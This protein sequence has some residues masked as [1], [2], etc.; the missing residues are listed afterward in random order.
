MAGCAPNATPSAPTPDIAFTMTPTHTL[1]PIPSAT[2]VP[3]KTPSPTP[4]RMAPAVD[5]T[6]L[7]GKVVFGYQGW[8]SCIGDG[9]GYANWQTSGSWIHWFRYYAEPIADALTVDFWP[10]TSEL[11]EDEICMTDMSLPDGRPA[12]AFSSYNLQTVV[13]HFQWMEEYGIDGVELNRFVTGLDNPDHLDFR[14]KVAQNVRTGA[15]I[16]G[17]FF[18]I[19]YDISGYKG[20]SLVSDIKSDWRHLVNTLKLTESPQYLHHRGLPVVGLYGFG[21]TGRNF[22]PDQTIELLDFFQSGDQLEYR[23]TV[24]GG[25]PSYWRTGTRD[26][27]KG[28]EWAQ[29]FR[30]FDIISPWA[31]GRFANYE[32]ADIFTREVTIPDLRETDSLGID[33]MPLVF[34]GFSWS[35]LYPSDPINSIPR[36]GGKFYWRQVFNAKSAGAK[37]L[38]IAMFDEVDEGTA[39][40]KLAATEQELPEGGVLVPLDIDGY[41]L[42]S[43]WYLRIGGMTGQMLREEIPLSTYLPIQPESLQ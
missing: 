1:T 4:T 28:P 40:F 42:P 27:E 22:T 18:Y 32:G 39:M 41:D 6:T 15:E 9:A 43:D 5:S 16:H 23:A 19:Q 2:L 7:E 31:V 37:M 35:N 36:N 17:R 20:S 30:S 24:K 13:R 11:T 8:F 34:P 29:V 25:V 38:Y 26:A 3:T 21:F 10:D 12:V 14:D 33:Y